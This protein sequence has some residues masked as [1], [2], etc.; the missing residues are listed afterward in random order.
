MKSD[1]FPCKMSGN[2]KNSIN[3]RE[4]YRVLIDYRSRHEIPNE[5]GLPNDA[6]CASCFFSKQKEIWLTNFSTLAYNEKPFHNISA[7]NESFA[8]FLS[9]S[10]SDL[11]E[12]KVLYEVCVTRVRRE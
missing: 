8:R 6:A 9:C 11:E 3:D 5:C 10:G 4:K 2:I 12:K 7:A 1:L